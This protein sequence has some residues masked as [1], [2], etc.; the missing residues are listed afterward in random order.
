MA[1]PICGIDVGAFSIKFVVFEIGFRQ[2]V[3]R[4]AFEEMI[5]EGPAP[6]MER[7]VEALREGLSRVS[8]DATLYLALP[9][10]ALSIR[11][12]ELPFTDQRKID[13]VIGYELE[14]QIVY[15][16][17]DVVFDHVVVRSGDDGSS[18]L[19]VAARRDVVAAWLDALKGK[20]IDPT[21]ALRGSGRVSRA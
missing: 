8:S 11:T 5:N 16:L 21:G 7:Q 20:G 13:Q 6:L 14:G 9:G 3:F 10:D 12:L 4:G 19:A 15:S 18:V 2:T 1:H 17:E